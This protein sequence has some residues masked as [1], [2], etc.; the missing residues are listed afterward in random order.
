VKARPD[1]AGLLAFG[2]P[3]ETLEMVDY[4]ETGIRA[5]STPFGKRHRFRLPEERHV[6]YWQD[7]RTD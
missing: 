5:E 4:T 2:A 1:G 6:P 7:V 3:A